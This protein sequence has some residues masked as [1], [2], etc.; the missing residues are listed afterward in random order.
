VKK[1]A[2]E[3]YWQKRTV[4]A[5]ETLMTISSIALTSGCERVPEMV[6]AYFASVA[7]G[8]VHDVKLSP[9]K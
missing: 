7:A 8:E 6:A 4:K 3:I 5:E 2:Y 1:S 9:Q